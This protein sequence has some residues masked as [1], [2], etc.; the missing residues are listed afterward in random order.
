MST[1][2]QVITFGI[3]SGLIWSMI[4]RGVNGLIE[5]FRFNEPVLII[6]AGLFAGAMTGVAVSVALKAPLTN[7]GWQRTLLFGLISLPL[8]ASVFG[9]VSTLL[10]EGLK[11]YQHGFFDSI[12]LAGYCGFMGIVFPFLSAYGIILF[13][14][15]VIT[16]FVLRAVINSG[17]IHAD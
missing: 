17:K 12:L 16:T 1:R 13:P 2:K 14:L 9:I 10:S 6:I 4:P 3:T 8:G 5:L 7:S 11:G 15:A